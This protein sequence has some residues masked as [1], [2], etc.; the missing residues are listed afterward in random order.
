MCEYKKRTRHVRAAHDRKLRAHRHYRQN[1]Q[2]LGSRAIIIIIHILIVVIV[3]SSLQSPRGLC[4]TDNP[5][6][7]YGSCDW[8]MYYAVLYMPNPSY[9]R[10]KEEAAQEDG[11]EDED[12]D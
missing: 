4:R 11:D 1:L 10:E 7:K 12:E 9:S 3:C 5:N 6:K 2:S 8:H